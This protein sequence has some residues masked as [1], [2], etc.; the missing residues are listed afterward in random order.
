MHTNIDHLVHVQGKT[1]GTYSFATRAFTVDWQQTTAYHHD[2]ASCAVLG[3]LLP[4]VAPRPLIALI[5]LYLGVTD[6]PRYYMFDET[7]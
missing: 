6:I 7:S 5:R 4:S 1:C 3:D 2:L